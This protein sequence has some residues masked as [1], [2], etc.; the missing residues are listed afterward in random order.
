MAGWDSALVRWAQAIGN[1]ADHSGTKEHGA[2]G[3][4]P[5][6][7]SETRVHLLQCV[8]A[9]LDPDEAGG[10]RRDGEREDENEQANE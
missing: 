5:R 2:P 7:L 9:V 1:V 4:L 10:E 6:P 3:P 8:H